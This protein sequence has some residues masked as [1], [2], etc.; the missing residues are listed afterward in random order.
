MYENTRA[1]TNHA[2][3]I[4]SINY[5]RHKAPNAWAH[6]NTKNMYDYEYQKAAIVQKIDT[7]SE[8]RI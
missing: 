8:S 2:I 5:P 1:R 4:C 6:G 3:F 7:E